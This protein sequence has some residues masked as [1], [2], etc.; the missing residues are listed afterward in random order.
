MATAT[1]RLDALGIEIANIRSDQ[2]SIRCDQ[3]SIRRDQESIGRDLECIRHDHA[4][5]REKIDRYNHLIDDYERQL[6]FKSDQEIMR[7]YI[8][9]VYRLKLSRFDDSSDDDSESDESDDDATYTSD[10]E[11]EVDLDDTSDEPE[12]GI[13]Q[14]PETVFEF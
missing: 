13:V 6:K 4:T 12:H 10:P 3:E 1:E 8:D 14:K 11:V 9:D 5:I 7:D 2:E